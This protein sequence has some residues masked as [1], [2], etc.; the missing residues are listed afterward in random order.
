MKILALADEPVERLWSKYGHDTLREA[1]LILSCGDLPPAYLS[2]MTCFT[3]AP[4]VYVPG[5]HDDRYEKTPPEGCI[6]ADGHVL[7]IKGLRILG[8]G[9]SIRYRPDCVNMYTE[10]EMAH[11]ISSLRGELR[12]TG[13]FDILMTH[14]PIAGLGDQKDLAH[15]GFQCLR[16]L[17]LRYRPAVMFHGHVHQAYSAA[18]F[19]RIRDLDGIPVVNACGSYQFDFPEDFTP[20]GKPTRLGLRG[21]K[22]RSEP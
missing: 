13:G 14:S 19:E 17:V 11:R 12:R 10:S 7:L 1:D 15:H 18:H 2:Y 16:P 8:L 9:G 4:V 21:M 5:N 6:N 3:G 20:T 22:K